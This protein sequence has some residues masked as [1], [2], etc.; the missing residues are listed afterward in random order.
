[1]REKLF[2]LP[3]GWRWGV[4][5]DLTEGVRGVSYRPEQLRGQG[6]SDVTQLLRS[7]NI[8]GGRVVYEDV[9][10]VPNEIVSD[11]QKAHPGDIAVCMSNGSKTLVGKS[12]LIGPEANSRAITVGSFCSLFKVKSHV[13]PEYVRQVLASEI[14]QEQVD[15]TLAGSAINNLKNSDIENFYCPI[16]PDLEQRG[17]AEVLSAL[18]EQ[19][20]HTVH[21]AHKAKLQAKGLATELLSC[22]KLSSSDVDDVLLSEVVPS[23]QYGISSSL[24]A[25]GE[26][27]VLRMNNLSGGEIS[28][29]DLKYARISI[30]PDLSLQMGDVL[31]NRTNSMEHVGRTAIWRGQLENATFASYLVRLNPDLTRLTPE[32]LVYLLEWD[33]HQ[34]QMRKFA[35]PGVQQV[36]INPT[37]LRRCRVRIPQSLALQRDAVAVLD[38]AREYIAELRQ[39]VSKLRLQKKGL[40]H[41]LLTGATRVR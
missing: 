27:P 30:S 35:T 24:E 13:A 14:F 9:Q 25:T 41:D 32:Y 11:R 4:L 8:Q 16:P 20:N 22:N 28:I 37:S 3:S 19:I 29:A 17:I 2:S 31:F 10:L 33:N 6:D 40:M 5:S 39:E 12:A 36:N 26:I 15:V 21:L 38:A 34:R 18:D 7:T 23:I 1:M